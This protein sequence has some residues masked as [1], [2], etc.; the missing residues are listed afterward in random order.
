MARPVHSKAIGFGN[1]VGVPVAESDAGWEM[2]PI[3]GNDDGLFEIL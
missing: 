3:F 1:G 2:A